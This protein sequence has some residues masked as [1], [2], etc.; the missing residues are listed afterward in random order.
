MKGIPDFA[1][2]IVWAVKVVCI[3]G[4]EE[5]GMKV[6]EDSPQTMFN[7]HFIKKAADNKH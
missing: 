5:K 6:A 7:P 3:V 1:S 4:A 2:D